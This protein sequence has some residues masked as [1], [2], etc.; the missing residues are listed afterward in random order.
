MSI[1]SVEFSSPDFSNFRITP[2]VPVEKEKFVS[3]QS[4]EKMT[5]SDFLPSFE[6]LESCIKD[7][8]R[9]SIKADKVEDLV[10]FTDR[11]K[12]PIFE[13]WTKEYIDAFGNYLMEQVEKMGGT[14]ENPVV[15]L[16]VGAG[17]GRLAHFLKEKIDKLV[18]DSIK[19][20][21]CDNYVTWNNMKTSPL[22]PVENISHKEALQKYK[23]KIVICS[24]MPPQSD[25]TKDF[26]TVESVDQY[27]LIGETDYGCC[28]NAWETWGVTG[29]NVTD[30]EAVKDGVPPYEKDGYDKTTLESL[31]DLQLS[32][33]DIFDGRGTSK[34]V[35]FERIK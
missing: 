14:K 9:D 8:R 3:E 21:A 15:I 31:S 13:I 35:S 24:W 10:K 33:A 23:P 1:D 27:I 11:E 6:N 26:R 25:L 22:F 20:V 4:L 18:P 19:I 12:N 16:E 17:N 34:T 7:F 30:N 5:D 29:Y 28:G 32:R 2:Q